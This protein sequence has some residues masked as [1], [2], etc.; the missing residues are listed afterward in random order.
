MPG[1]VA[2]MHVAPF[3]HRAACAIC[4]VDEQHF[5]SALADDAVTD[6]G[7]S[8]AGHASASAGLAG[9]DIPDD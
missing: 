7:T 6:A 2:H 4:D 8:G 5:R 1:R 3:R 9:K